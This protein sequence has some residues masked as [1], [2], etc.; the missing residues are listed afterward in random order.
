[1]AATLRDVVSANLVLVG[2]DLLNEPDE[3]ERFRNALDIDLRL[4]VGLVTNL[5]SGLTEP[6]RT[7]TLNRERIALNLSSSRS[8]IAREYPEQPDLT[9]LAQIA[10]LAIGDAR[11]A[12]GQPPQAFGY[13]IEMVFDQS[14]G[15]PAIRYIGECLFGHQSFGKAGWSLLGGTGQLIFTDDASQ[16][17]ITIRPQPGDVATTRVLLALNLHKDEQRF[18]TESESKA[19]LEEVWNEAKAFMNRLDESGAL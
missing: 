7:L 1:M 9:R 17:T 6:S 11:C 19:S 16:W 2:I 15:Q 3:V 10:E 18:P 12:G 5:P 13:N 8:S 4:E 14:S